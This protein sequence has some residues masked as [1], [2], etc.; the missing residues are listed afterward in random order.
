M[1]I[2]EEVILPKTS[3]I[4]K[5]KEDSLSTIKKTNLEETTAIT[6][7]GRCIA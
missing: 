7:D 5:E 4:T 2:I 3:D 1:Y 6:D